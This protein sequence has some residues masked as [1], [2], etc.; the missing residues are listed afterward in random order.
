MGIVHNHVF[1]HHD[2]FVA[3]VGLSHISSS[4]RADD[5]ALTQTLEYLENVLGW[6]S[7]TQL[8]NLE[9][10]NPRVAV[11]VPGRFQNTSSFSHLH[12]LSLS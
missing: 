2:A 7:P 5:P 10:R 8:V 6:I 11:I 4:Q 12:I 3:A 1:I 9:V